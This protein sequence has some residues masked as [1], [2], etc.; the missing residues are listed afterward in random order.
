MLNNTAIY[1]GVIAARHERARRG[2]RVGYDA[3]LN[4]LKSAMRI[5]DGMVVLRK[6]PREGQA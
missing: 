1:D 6:G 3:A 2:S 5:E 4:Y